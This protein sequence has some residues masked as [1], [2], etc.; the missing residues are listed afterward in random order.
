M[1]RLFD[2]SKKRIESAKLDA[3]AK[4]ALEAAKLDETSNRLSRILGPQ[5]QVSAVIYQSERRGKWR[6]EHARVDEDYIFQVFPLK[7]IPYSWPSIMTA[8]I[9][10]LDQVFPRT[11]Q[12]YYKPPSELFKEPEFQFYT[13]RFKNLFTTPGWE[14]GIAK[15]MD[16]LFGLDVWRLSAKR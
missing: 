5:Q 4:A 16:A 3:K 1:G 13:I 8:F 12:I 6:I 14:R 2:G 11:V 15:A 9:Q 7:P 10:V